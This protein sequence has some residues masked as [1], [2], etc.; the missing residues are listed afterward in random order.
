MF[1][2]YPLSLDIAKK[3]HI[4]TGITLRMLSRNLYYIMHIGAQRCI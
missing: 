2:R 4:F 3:K 1:G